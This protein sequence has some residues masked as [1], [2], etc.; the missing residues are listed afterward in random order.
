MK[1][2]FSPFIRFLDSWAAQ[3]IVRVALF[4]QGI[5]LEEWAS[6]NTSPYRKR[7][8][9]IKLVTQPDEAEV[10]ALHGPITD[11]SFQALESW[12]SGSQK[13]AKL[14]AV[15]AEIEINKEGRIVSPNGE[16]STFKVDR[17]LPGHPPTP[18]DLI[19]AIQ[20]LMEPPHV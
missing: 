15:G 10:L 1:N 5:A 4:G 14:L 6:L 2:I 13:Y 18:E 20:Q 19:L 3:K 11:L 8:P 17:I 7:K 16:A 9:N 12:V